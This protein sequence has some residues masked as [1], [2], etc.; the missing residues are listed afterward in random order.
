MWWIIIEDRPVLS[1]I[2]L[3]V[4]GIAVLYFARL[5]M[6]RLLRKVSR[7]LV[8][9]LRLQA[10]AITR[11]IDHLRERNRDVLLEMGKRRYERLLNRDFHRINQMVASDFSNYPELQKHISMLVARLEEDYHRS[12]EIAPP[13]PDWVEAIEAIV[14]LKEA[15]KANPVIVKVLEDLHTSLNSHQKKI[16]TAYRDGVSERHKLLHAMMPSWR[17]LNNSVER[18]GGT[19][20]SLIVQAEEIDKN[21]D[22]YRAMTAGTEKAERMLQVSALREW[23]VSGFW[24]VLFLGGAYFNFNLMVLP[25]SEMVGSSS[26]VMGFSMAEI[27][28]LMIVLIE[29][30]IGLLLMEVLHITRMFPAVGALEDNK[31]K[32]LFWVLLGLIILFAVTSA[33][34]AFLRDQIATDAA[35]LQT[36]L[37]GGERV[38]VE[39]GSA[40]SLFVPQAA[41]MFLG[42]FLPFV[43][44]FLAVPFESFLDSSRMVA[45]RLLLLFLHVVVLTL[46]LLSATVGYM[47]EILLAI[48]DVVIA[49]PLWIEHQLSQH[50]RK[51]SADAALVEE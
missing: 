7:L 39:T 31:R 41:H 20:R 5:P 28:A 45:A 12:A 35:A 17:R 29:V 16:L 2:L 9:L 15:Q 11:T 8:H 4:L 34:L 48:Y 21:M 24:L 19:M 33:G 18:V 6:H 27:S 40:I 1:V 44:V 47:V 22:Q 43:L 37:I 49:L 36:L 38:A 51:A 32:V 42:F 50:T 23:L 26:P 25:M 46:K 14:N 13:S 30:S 10:K 3:A